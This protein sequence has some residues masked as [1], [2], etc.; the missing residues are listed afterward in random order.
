MTNASAQTGKRAW[1][2]DQDRVGKMSP[3]FTSVPTG[4]GTIAQWAVMKDDT[5]PSP[6]NVLA[7]TSTDSTD[8]RFPLAIV[9]ETSYK[10][11]ALN[12]KF[13]PISGKVDQGAGLVF[14]L[15][16]KDNYYIV[17]SPNTRESIVAWRTPYQ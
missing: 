6:P 12:V 5:A 3:G 4:Q 7:Q 2:F 10:D 17:R 15:R 9:D 11:L 16:D 13:K 8:Y 1:S 14:R